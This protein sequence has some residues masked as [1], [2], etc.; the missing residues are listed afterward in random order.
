MR[1]ASGFTLFEL[2]LV[3]GIA[4]IVAVLAVVGVRAARRNAAVGGVSFDLVLRLQGLKTRALAEQRDH[5]AVLHAGDGAGCELLRQAGCVRLFVLADPQATWTLQA[6]TPANP[7]NLTG[8][9]VDTIIFPKGILLDPAAAGTTGRAPFGAVQTWDVGLTGDC[10]GAR[11][12]AFRFAADGRVRGEAPDG[13]SLARPG[14]ILAL[15]TDLQGE[16]GAAE[17]RAVLVSFPAGIVKSYT[18]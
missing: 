11:C 18:Y 13:T 6:F 1:R 17:R 5:L 15:A 12:I 14:H 4:A 2:A 7:G 10:G 3:I 9:L 16:T 8:E